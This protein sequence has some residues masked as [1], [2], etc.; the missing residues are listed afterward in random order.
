MALGTVPDLEAA[1]AHQ[2]QERQ[3][4]DAAQDDGLTIVGELLPLTGAYG[5]GCRVLQRV[6]GC[7][8]QPGNRQG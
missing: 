6:R 5:R 3:C 1:Q 2:A 7:K 8:G 4:L